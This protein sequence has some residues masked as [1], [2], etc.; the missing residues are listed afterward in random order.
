MGV[1]VVSLLHRTRYLDN[2][3]IDHP[4][5]WIVVD[6]NGRSNLPVPEQSGSS[7]TDLF[8]LGIRHAQISRGELYYNSRPYAISADLQDLAFDS[9][10][11]TPL[12][13]YSGSLAYSQG[14]LIVG[15]FRPLQHDLKWSL[16][17]PRRDSRSS[18]VP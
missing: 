15:T 13:R 11:S 6:K 4:V 9:I 8:Q 10:F 16:R 5:A 3:Q 18:K 2:V 12:T 1:R 7:H 14:K 17:Q